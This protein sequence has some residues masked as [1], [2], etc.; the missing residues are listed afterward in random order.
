MNNCCYWKYWGKARGTEAELVSASPIWHPFAY[1]S[2]DVAAV[3]TEFL[4]LSPGTLAK[5]SQAV[6]V[7]GEERM[8]ELVAWLRFFVALHDIG[9]LHAV[10]QSQ[11]FA[12]LACCWPELGA[13][14]IIRPVSRYHHGLN[15]FAVCELEIADW[16]GQKSR[17]WRRQFKLWLAAVMGHHGDLPQEG[18]FEAS[19][20]YA[21]CLPE[22]I[23][24]DRNARRQ[25]VKTAAD[26]FLRPEGLSLAVNQPPVCSPV[27]QRLI[28]G[29]CSLCDWIG[30]DARDF[31]YAPLN[32]T[33]EDYF[34]AR[35]GW[36]RQVDLLTRKG[37]CASARPYAGVEA[38]LPEGRFARGVQRLLD[39][40]S[41]E[42]ALTIVEAPTGTG[43]TE[44]AL[45]L[46]W[47]LL[48]AKRADS[49]ILALPT[50]ATANAMLARAQG[51]GQRVFGAASLVL[52]HGKSGFYPGF[53][54]LVAAGRTTTAQGGLDAG[55]QC[56]EWLA[57]SRKRVFLGQI[58]ICTVDQVLLSA[59]PVKHSFVRAL[60]VARSV[61]IVDEVHAYDAYMNGILEEILHRQRAAG[62][63]A[64]LLSATLPSG[65]R[66]RLLSAW[67][68]ET[69]VATDPGAPYPVVWQATTSIQSLEL[70]DGETQPNG[71][72][73]ATARREVAVELTRT[74]DACP[75]Q[76]LLDQVVAA[77]GKGALVGMVMNTVAVAQELGRRLRSQTDLPVDLFHSRYRLRDRQRI[78]ADVIARYGRDG[79]RDQGRILVAT[80]VIEQS[81]DLDF[82]WLVT[83][84]C[85]VDLL[86]QRIGR[87]HRHQRSRPGGF[88]WP[89]ATVLSTPQD[90]F[91]LFEFIYG[92]S[93]VLWRTVQLLK[94]HQQVRFPRVYREWIERVY[95]SDWETEEPEQVTGQHYAW[96]QDQQMARDEAIRLTRQSV[97][98]FQD[99]Q[100]SVT[101][102]TRDGEMG[103]TVLPV[104]EDERLLNILPI[105]ELD[106]FDRA[107]Q[108][109]LDSVPVPGTRAW[110][111]LFHDMKRDREGRIRMP[112]I[113]EGI[114]AKGESWRSVDGR[115]SYSVNTGL[116]KAGREG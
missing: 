70:T 79:E 94:D 24:H 73:D 5:I 53:R 12:A 75:D 116:E 28:A 46:A 2:L 109:M 45:A 93:R 60:G 41:I 48:A 31:R 113:P 106:D 111:N 87:L 88:D 102:L 4:R 15:G 57:S 16:L 11:S 64:I 9:K 25:W 7:V 18:G 42:P 20:S 62:G 66:N 96:L 17:R 72:V 99:D 78:E 49:V 33:A 8:A 90:E 98:E 115:F 34:D 40:C 63:S 65:V 32:E 76:A 105:E 54:D 71:D 74:P 38:L 56:A 61:L 89:V 51:F 58:G 69:G 43:K 112:M 14:S 36:I 6:G 30:S 104:L 37:L 21:G 26:I 107:E 101:S 47:R 110:K 80:Q 59:L 86:F 1:H 13:T 3:A 55:V 23:E 84:I 22:I 50:Q 19:R 82:D 35:C 39:R 83:Q 68:D 97:A 29:F 92:D 52:A 85:P 77:A 108:L 114:P 27:A 67:T 44:A 10:F 91:G 100:D 81:L 103:L 95:G